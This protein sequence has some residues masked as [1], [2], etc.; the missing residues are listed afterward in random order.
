MKKR[1]AAKYIAGKNDIAGPNLEI[2]FSK[3]LEQ[4]GSEITEKY[5]KELKAEAAQ[6][7]VDDITRLWE[8]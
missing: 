8:K 6:L 4:T 1:I 2:E 3:M 5:G 7:K